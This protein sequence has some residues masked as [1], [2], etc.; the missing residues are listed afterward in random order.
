L[1]EVKKKYGRIYREALILHFVVLEHL[2]LSVVPFKGISLTKRCFRGFWVLGTA[3]YLTDGSSQSTTTVSFD[4]M[5]KPEKTSFSKVVK[6]AY[7]LR[8]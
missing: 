5:S 8:Y 7:R 1:K 6:V 2:N 3:K 4:G